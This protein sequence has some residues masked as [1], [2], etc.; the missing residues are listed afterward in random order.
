MENN[1]KRK[2]LGNNMLRLH[3]PSV[4]FSFAALRWWAQMQ[5]PLSNPYGVG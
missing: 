3:L 5:I 1:E 2:F 4:L